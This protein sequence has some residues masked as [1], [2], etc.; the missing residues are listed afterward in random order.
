VAPLGL[1][2]DIL[3]AG[4]AALEAPLFHGIIEVTHDA[5]PFPLSMRPG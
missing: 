2:P 1:K 4:S 5:G 3:Q